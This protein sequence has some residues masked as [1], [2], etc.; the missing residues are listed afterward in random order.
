MYGLPRVL[1]CGATRSR[2]RVGDIPSMNVRIE[3]RRVAPRHEASVI[4]TSRCTRR[5]PIETA[6]LGGV[7]SLRGGSSRGPGS[8]QS[9]PSASRACLD[10]MGQTCPPPTMGEAEVRGDPGVF[11]FRSDYL[12][13][14]HV[15]YEACSDF[16]RGGAR[17]RHA[18]A[19]PR[20][21]FNPSVLVARGGFMYILRFTR[22]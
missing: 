17:R 19:S 21:P 13:V 20:P 6:I 15:M 18:V 4:E 3:K 8:D 10:W 12:H 16:A 11:F 14:R 22:I 5:R 1:Q 2:S 7:K 9:R